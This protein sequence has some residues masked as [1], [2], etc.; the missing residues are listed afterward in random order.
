MYS[1]SY[2]TDRHGGTTVPSG[3]DGCAFDEEKRQQ[4]LDT[5]P[6]L[7]NCNGDGGYCNEEIGETKETS[8][9]PLSGGFLSGILGPLFGSGGRGGFN[10]K[11]PKIGTEEILI[12]ATAFFLLFS[13]DGD[14]ECALLLLLLL[15][16]N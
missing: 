12:I 3:Y 4:N 7:D 8:A 1:R 13:K 5:P 15:L 6:V 10:L 14:I 9:S 11:L 16:I 2:N